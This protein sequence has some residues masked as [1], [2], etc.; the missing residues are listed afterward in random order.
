MEVV[1]PERPVPIRKSAF[2]TAFIDQRLFEKMDILAVPGEE[3]PIP[4]YT[5][6]LVEVYSSKIVIARFRTGNFGWV[7]L[8]R[9]VHKTLD[10]VCICFATSW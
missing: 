6:S 1:S 4:V 9:S 7:K 3:D 8:G 2:V 5:K 10:G